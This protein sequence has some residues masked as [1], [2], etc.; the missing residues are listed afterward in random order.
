M[1]P[2]SVA[3][4]V[5]ITGA[6]P[7]GPL[8]QAAVVRSVTADS[9][10]VG[11]GAL[12]VA[13]PGE[14]VDGR[15]FVPAAVGAGAV[16]ALTTTP[17]A[18]APC[19]VVPDPLAAFGLIA[20]RLVDLG[21]VGGLQV[22]GLTGSQGKTSTKDLLAVILE[23]D[24]PTVAPVGNLNNE[25]GLPLTVA[26]LEPDTRYLVAEMGARGIGHIAYLCGICP[27]TVGIE[28]NV[29]HAHV[30]E[31]GGQAAIARAKSEL[32]AALRADGTAVLNID[33]PYVW[34]MRAVTPA[35][36]LAFSAVGEPEFGDAVWGSGVALDDL[37]RARFSLHARYGTAPERTA[38]VRLKL[39]GRHHVANAAAAAAAA[40]ALGL[41]LDSI[42]AALSAATARS[43]WRMELTE[44]ADGLV[45]L[46]DAYNANPESMAAALD[47]LAELGRRRAAARTWALLGDMLELGDEA[48]DAHRALGRRVAETGIDR[49]IV[50]GR[51]AETVA[52]EAR[53]AGLDA[54]RI[55][56]AADKPAMLV[57]VAATA[58]GPDIVLVKAS[59]GL[60][61][62]T[63]AADL[64]TEPGRAG[65]PAGE[66][67]AS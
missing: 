2:L 14:R 43:R 49:L 58:H 59:R 29:G 3:G 10:E 40:V 7:S 4:L 28:L 16:A 64:L 55:S 54:D 11:P 19:L 31:F 42:A 57:E 38:D 46:N 27:P 67:A 53:S 24:G 34:G 5:A 21:T 33:D 26:R 6:S 37:G 36:V 23:A 65:R 20:R 60:A 25:L 15:D 8:D 41:E 66:D 35:R 22:V 30:G 9:R 52:A 63:V 56:V 62:D 44:R 18:G 13:L 61:L 32:V 50:V 12:F 17:I 1:I 48:D 51:Y 39:V 45:V 47:A